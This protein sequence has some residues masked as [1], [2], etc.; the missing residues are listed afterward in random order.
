MKFKKI[1]PIIA[2]FSLTFLF[3]FSL[4]I[5][6]QES[7]TMDEQAHIPASYTYV[8]Y[9]DMR[10]N[11]EHPPLL[12]NLAGIPLLF[13]DVTFPLD[14]K[15]WQEGVN[16]QWVLGNRFL[17]E[18][19]AH[20]ITFF[21][22]IPIIF[23]SIL[24]GFFLFFWTKKL[25]GDIPAI[26]AIVFYSFN[27][28]VIAHSH[29]VTTDIGIACAI[30]IT[31]YFGTRFIKNPSKKNIILFGLV[32]GIAQLVKFSAF[33]LYPFFGLLTLL[34][35]SSLVQKYTLS[36]ETF[37]SLWKNIYFYWS[38]FFL[39]SLISLI[40]IWILYTFNTWNMPDAQL[41]TLI[42]TQ[43]PESGIPGI[44]KA[45]VLFV[46]SV[47]LLSSLTEYFLGLAMV[48]VRVTGGNTYYFLGEV[49][50]VA[51]P[52]YFPTVY[53][54]KE[55]LP[56]LFSLF[57]LPFLTI[58]IFFQKYHALF[59]KKFSPK[60]LFS[61]L[62]LA[63][64]KKIELFAIILFCILYG[65]L[66]ISGNLNIG[67]RHLFPIVPLLYLL[68]ALSLGKLYI[69][70]KKFGKILIP[71][72]LLW[73]VII[74]LFSYPSYLSYYN[75]SVGGS[76]N[77]YLYVTDSNYDWGQDLR[78]LKKWVDQY[79]TQCIN[80]SEGSTCLEN[81][82]FIDTIRIDYFGGSNPL[83]WFEE[84]YIPWNDKKTPEPG[85]YALSA[86]YLQESI[87]KEKTPHEQSYLWTKNA[88]LIDKAGDS[89]FIFYL[90][91]SSF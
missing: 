54:L 61:F 36:K 83:Y 16:Q 26:I 32:L 77:G 68:G 33:L 31:L 13:M 87:Y 72:L 35:A 22:R 59:S 23:I 91:P 20:L 58:K 76:K 86:T 43:L 85:W 9:L 89:L 51:N 53:L 39:I 29:Y 78:R 84:K 81:E 60:N 42:E 50:T 37:F 62:L 11:P 56:V 75:E 12:K 64:Q 47:P 15:E 19:N 44:A 1:S 5:S 30:F 21:S 8:K 90:S 49:S 14:S 7:T 24:L 4:F 34:Y 38:R 70:Y 57:L 17:H 25:A 18:N 27:P 67:F 45:F 46:F 2:S 40:P 74:P 55:T 80:N 88:K 48:F 82:N 10:L 6:W 69:H 52:L 65:Y 73:T 66:S 79:N 3:F 71:L 28:N 41:L 63:I